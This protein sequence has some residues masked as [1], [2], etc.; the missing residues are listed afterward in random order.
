MITR[1]AASRLKPGMYVVDPGLDEQDAPAGLFH[2]E[3]EVVDL[4]MAEE[5]RREGFTEAYID[6][7]RSAYFK[8]HPEE[9]EVIL[10][11]HAAAHQQE[12]RPPKGPDPRTKVCYE[13][14]RKAR[15]IYSAAMVMVKS[16]W[17]D[18]KQNRVTDLAGA[19]SFVDDVLATLAEDPHAFLALIKHQRWDEYEYSHSLNVAVIAVCFGKY[20]QF[21]DEYCR[22]LGV[23]GLYHDVGKLR[24][25]AAVLNKPGRLGPE[26]LAVMRKHP[27]YGYEMLT[28]R[29]GLDKETILAAL[30]HHERYDGSGYPR[31]LAFK[32]INK[33]SNLISLAD[34]Y[35]AT[36]SQ[37]AYEDAHS[38][39][40]ALS[41]MYTLRGKSFHPVLTEK[42]IRF[43]GVY[44]VGGLV[45]LRNGR[46]AVVVNQNPED[47]LRPTVRVIAEG[48]GTRIPPLDLD[49]ADPARLA[50]EVEIIDSLKPGAF[51]FALSDFYQ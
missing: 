13:T 3:G 27:A 9:R 8:T 19:A 44:P 14:I 6:V 20:L 50:P 31:G 12:E 22:H 21:D 32:D 30:E 42:F 29:R 49:L 11:A 23:A 18:L 48:D 37:R 2:F 24:V 43:L 46:V 16:M 45:R 41:I 34:V 38:P 33:L 47:M 7:E 39:H 51:R 17:D 10:K 28:K 1:I 35:D 4:A 25:P 5:I 40:N 36:T 26:E 15:R